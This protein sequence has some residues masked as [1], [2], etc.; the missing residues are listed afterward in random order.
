MILATTAGKVGSAAARVLAEQGEP[1]RVLI[2]DPA[3]AADLAR[4]G[5]EAEGSEE[6]GQGDLAVPATVGTALPG[7]PVVVLV[8]PAVPDQEVNIIAGSVLAGVWLHA[9]HPHACVCDPRQL[10]FGS[11]TGEGRIGM[12]GHP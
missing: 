8:G 4:A 10:R 5:A 11:S 7:A 1:V 3:K 12:G 2:R 9:E 6:L